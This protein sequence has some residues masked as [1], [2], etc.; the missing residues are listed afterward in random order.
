MGE[1]KRSAALSLCFAKKTSFGDVYICIMYIYVHIYIS[2]ELPWIK[3]QAGEKGCPSSKLAAKAVSQPAKI[4]FLKQIGV[5]K[6]GGKPPKWMA[7][8]MENPIKMDDLG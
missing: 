8:F 1:K 7:Y 3:V 5:S 6:I 4:A 2:L